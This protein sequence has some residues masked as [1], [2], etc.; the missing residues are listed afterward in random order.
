MSLRRAIVL[1]I[2]ALALATPGSALAASTVSYASAGGVTAALSYSGGPG[3]T[4]EDERLKITQN[5]SVVYDQ[6]V[7]AKGCF[8]VCGPGDKEPIHVSD[9]YGDGSEDVV[10]DL[11]SGGA[12]CCTI[13]QVYVS[14]AAVNS[15]VMDEHNFGEAGAV[16]KDIGPG[17]RPEFVSGNKAFY[18]QLTFCAASGLPLQIFE[19]TEEKFVDVTKQHPKLITADAARWIKLY[20]KDPTAGQGLIAAW[21]ADED[22]LGL[23]ANVRTVLQLQTADGHLKASFVETLQRFLKRHGY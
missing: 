9:L 18:C 5:G 13:E 17:G 7:P 15:Y 3:I 20:Y 4:T 1:S 16:L 21:A 19:F 23:Q 8:R 2:L 14:S 6:A 11:F 10:L 22:N 12:D